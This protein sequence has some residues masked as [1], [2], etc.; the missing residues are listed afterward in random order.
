MGY[1]YCRLYFISI[2]FLPGKVWAECVLKLRHRREGRRWR[3]GWEE[4]RTRS[5]RLTTSFPT[6]A[7][8]SPSC[9]RFEFIYPSIHFDLTDLIMTTNSGRFMIIYSFSHACISSFIRPYLATIG[10][11]YRQVGRASSPHARHPRP[12]DARPS[13]EGTRR[14]ASAIRRFYFLL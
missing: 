12:S 8:S 2:Y 10:T 1:V 3:T 9:S 7:S 6:T 13:D 11:R 4:P 14:G 5:R